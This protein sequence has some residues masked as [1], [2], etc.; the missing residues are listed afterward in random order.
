MVRQ[1]KHIW[2]IRPAP[3]LPRFSLQHA[4]RYG[5]Y[6]PSHITAAHS[7][8]APIRVVKSAFGIFTL[9]QAGS[10]P[11]VFQNANSGTDQPVNTLTVGARPGQ[12]VII[13]GTGLGPAT[14]DEADRRGF[15]DMPD[16]PVEVYVGGKKAEIS[17]RGRSGCCAAID[18]IVFAVPQGVE[19]CY[20]PV[21]V[22]VGDVVSNFVT[23]S[24]APNGGVCTDPNGI[25]GT[26]LESAQRSGTFRNG[27]VS[28]TRSVSKFSFPD[29]AVSKAR[30]MMARRHFSGITLTSLSVRR[31]SA[32]GSHQLWLLHCFQQPWK[33]RD[34]CRRR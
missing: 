14:R 10:G 23:M 26:Q 25:S 4:R 21:V 1:S 29:S 5:H 28:L 8:T 32:A 6:R 13:W 30:R 27:G 34:G 2:S 7:A 16:R 9:N 22:K 17:Y 18:Q 12:L 33:L 11:G 24:V 20:V 15:G 19:G 3:S 31:V